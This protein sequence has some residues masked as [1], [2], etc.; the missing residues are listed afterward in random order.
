MWGWGIKHKIGMRTVVKLPDETVLAR[1]ANVS[2]EGGFVGVLFSS[3]G[4]VVTCTV[5]GQDIA[6]MSIYTGAG[7]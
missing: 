7:C 3:R 4:R 6:P 5:F 1:I 2:P